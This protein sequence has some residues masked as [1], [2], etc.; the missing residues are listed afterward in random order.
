MNDRPTIK[1]VARLAQVHFTTVSMAMRGHPS[2]PAVTRE[3]I[4]ATA[5][6]IGYQRNEVFSA[7]TRRRSN[8]GGGYL[9][10]RIAYLANQ[11]PEE[12]YLKV[13]HNVLFVAGA[14][15]QA[16][17]LGYD[18]E[19]VYV[20]PGHHDSRSLD[21]YLKSRSIRGF[22]IG[23][24]IPGRPDLGVDWNDY[25][26]AK[27]NSRHVA[28]GVPFVSNDQYGEV[29][30]AFSNLRRLGYR[31]IGLAVGQPDEQVTDG[32]H[33]SA[34]LLEQAG[35]PAR[36]RV[37]PLLFPTEANTSREVVPLL[38]AWI[39]SHRPDAVLCTWATIADMIREA[40]FD[41]PGKVACASLCL[42][43]PD[44]AVAGIVAS[45]EPVGEQAASLL[46]AAL[47]AETRGIPSLATATYVRGTWFDG[48]T[49]PNRV[50]T[51]TEA[52]GRSPEG[53]TSRSSYQI[54]KQ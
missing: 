31:R 38:R 50:T 2:I 29:R 6:R 18:F 16:E 4:L 25:A 15:R 22:I 35:I 20:A 30:C 28:P 14:R 43:K 33:Q 48:A 42:S 32:M 45:L 49:A 54:P 47:R 7:L 10:P 3:R 1:D 26:V 51:M 9:T 52:R 36:D 39:R 24:F 46:V 13:A 21:H 44:P 12:G 23:S 41:C 40:G 19:L 27:I 34:L 17:A 5:N 11:S 53:M 37:P 8:F